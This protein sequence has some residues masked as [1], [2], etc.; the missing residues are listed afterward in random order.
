MDGSNTFKTCPACNTNYE[1]IYYQRRAADEPP[2]EVSYC[3]NCPVD[4]TKLKIESNFT[5][6]D[7]RDIDN[8]KPSNHKRNEN[9][10]NRYTKHKKS[11]TN[12]HSLRDRGY[13]LSMQIQGMAA[14]R[15]YKQIRQRDTEF[16]PVVVSTIPVQIGN[17]K[18]LIQIHKNSVLKDEGHVIV[19]SSR[20]APL[21]SLDQLAVYS[22]KEDIT[23]NYEELVVAYETQINNIEG[24]DFT[25]LRT[26]HEGR[27]PSLFVFLPIS[28]NI[29]NSTQY[30]CLSILQ[31]I[32]TRYGTE[33][34]IKS[35]VSSQMISTLYVQSSK[36]YDWPSA[37]DQGYVYTWKPDGER[38]WYLRYGSVWLF[39]RR[40]LSGRI[41][42][43][44]ISTSLIQADKVGP[45]LD[46]EVLIRHPPILMDLLVSDSGKP[47]PPLRSLDLVLETFKHTNNIDVPI[48]VRDY[49]K[50]QQDLLR[51][52]SYIS[53]P[54]DG[55]VG[56]QDN[57]M[58][59]IKLK[60]TKSIE[61]KLKDNG[62]LVSA[63]NKTV[64]LSELHNTYPIDSI[65]EVRFT[66]QSSADTFTITETL[67][68][69]D[70]T[71]ANTYE[72]CEDII[73]TISSM[74]DTLA[75][76]N[77]VQWCS[78]IRQ[79]IN[80]I[81]SKPTGKGRVIMD[82]GAGDGQAISDY[83]TDPN[84][85]YILV[86][87][88]INKCQKLMKRLMEPGKGKSRLFEGSE[89][90]TRVVGLVSNRTLKYAVICS[91]IGDILNEQHCIRTLK[92]CVR[93]SIASFSISHTV[94]DLQQLALG[95]I[96][97]IGCGYMY[98]TVDNTGKLV[99][100]S[101]VTMQLMDKN[102]ASVKWG[103]DKV[104][105]ER[106][107]RLQDFST[108]FHTRLATSLVPVFNDS[109]SSLLNT[110]SSKVYIISTK[111]YI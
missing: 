107:I 49:Y 41:T 11:L 101:G 20:I 37:P 27:Q 63:E 111:K 94:H 83:T 8:T 13:R 95:G 82:I 93:Y 48:F 90:I 71:K 56:I 57:S 33:R 51:T 77:A 24:A 60:D 42:G 98:D 2:D 12:L 40:L 99:N 5:G 102:T 86:E 21:I 18:K 69:T 25:I 66:K 88:D 7:N 32:L 100:E 108:V 10:I 65:I 89:H 55:V 35:F 58:N 97:I 15:C 81:A 9:S 39:S 73:N 59:I 38:F 85:T 79:K 36:A 3:I 106:V 31:Q 30:V 68:R 53:Y 74:P 105:K 17:A 78:S 87:P 52:K 28:S 96:D 109:Q 29:G 70:K 6:Q 22:Q 110:I 72:V 43:W 92:A 84:I 45:V 14:S 34:T 50:S 26:S 23:N 91:K 64:I 62:N 19:K 47:T 54:I 16:E 75:R 104:Y 4:I 46:V 44:N 76:R 61:L 80:Q 67:L 103:G 1:T